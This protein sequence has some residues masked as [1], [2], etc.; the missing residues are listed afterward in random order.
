MHPRG[1]GTENRDDALYCT[2]CGHMIEP[3]FDDF[4]EEE[5]LMN[6]EESGTRKENILLSESVTKFM[7]GT[8]DRALI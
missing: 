3:L 2:G 7:D 6:A 4:P 5:L 8:T 1:C